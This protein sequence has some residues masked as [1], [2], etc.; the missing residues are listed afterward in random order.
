MIGFAF[1]VGFEFLKLVGWVGGEVLTSKL[2]S[3]IVFLKLVLTVNV[4]VVVLFYW[5]LFSK[6][7]NF[8]MVSMCVLLGE[9]PVIALISIW[10]PFPGMVD[11]L[12]LGFLQW[13]MF[14]AIW[15]SYLQRS[16]RV[17]VTVEH[18]VKENS[19]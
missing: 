11:P 19:A 13:V 12:A 14:C 17:R 8:R 15:V 4:P 6:N 7:P 18:M 3:K 10:Y 16:R 9:W 5:L 2:P 1:S